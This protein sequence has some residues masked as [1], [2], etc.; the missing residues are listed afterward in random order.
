VQPTDHWEAEKNFALLKEEHP[1]LVQAAKRGN[2]VSVSVKDPETGAAPRSR[3][4]SLASTARGGA[5][6][7][8]GRRPSNGE[9]ASGR[10]VEKDVMEQK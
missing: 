10:I 8:G 2:S 6:L 5:S 9:R 4:T 3:G 7:A 1:E